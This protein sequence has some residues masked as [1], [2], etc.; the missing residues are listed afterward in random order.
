MNYKLIIVIIL[1]SLIL[2]CGEV[3]TFPGIEFS[4]ITRTSE[5]GP[6]PIGEIDE[7]DWLKQFDY[8]VLSEDGTI[9]IP[10]SYTV[11]PAYPNPTS[12]FTNIKF[13]IPKRDSVIIVMIDKLENKQTVLLSKYLQAGIH[14]LNID[15]LYSNSE[16]IR[17]EGLIRIHFYIP[18]VNNFPEVHG[19]IE[20]KK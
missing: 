13:A 11:Y 3:E 1:L 19:D 15:L 6:E 20:Y 2:N 4:G 9:T 14:I 12:R 8:N 16:M 5:E 10:V 17:K 7:T 18:T